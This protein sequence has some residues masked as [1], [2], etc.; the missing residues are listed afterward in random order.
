M[1]IKKGK[2]PIKIWT[3]IMES[4]AM[5]QAVNLSNLPFAFKHIAIMPDTH[6]GIGCPIGSVVA[7]NGIIV[8]NLIGVDIGCVDKDTEFLSPKGWVKISKYKKEEVA[9]FNPQDNYISFTK[10]LAY[11]K[12]K[13]DRFIKI[14]TKYGVD[15]MLSEDHRC[16]I[17]KNDFDYFDMNAKDLMDKHNSLKLGYRHKIKTSFYSEGYDSYGVG[18]SEEMLR[19]LVMFSADGSY[20][21]KKCILQFKK[22][23]KI[24]RAEMLL[25]DADILYNKSVHKNGI[26]R[27]SFYANLKKG[28][29]D[30]WNANKDQ[31][32]IIAEECLYWDGNQKDCF[33][34]SRKE[35]ADFIHYVF[36]SIGYRSVIRLDRKNEYRVFKYNNDLVGI[37]GTPKTKITYSKSK[38]GYKYCFTVPT[39]YLV[40]RRNGNIF[41]TGN[42]GMCAVKTSLTEIDKEI[43][44]KIMGEIRKV[45]PVGF[46][47]H[48]EY[49]SYQSRLLPTMSDDLKICN[50]EFNNA[51]LSLGTLGG[52]NHFIEIQKGSDGFIWIMIHSGSR[53]LG[54]K[55]AEHY[56]K[57]AIELNKK[58]YSE[59]P[60]S[61]ELAYLPVDSAEGQAYIKEMEYCVE[62][63]LANRKLMM[64]RIINCF[65]ENVDVFTCEP[66]INIAHNYASLEN[67]FGE[68]VWV[69]RKGA[70]LAT[71]NTIG[72]IPGSQG[73]KSYIVKG[74][75]NTESFMSCSHG[76]GRLMSRSKAKE[77]LNLANEIKILDDQGI[78]HGIKNIDDLDEASSAY[79]DIDEVME[80][81]KDLVEILVELKPLAVIKG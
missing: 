77:N 43:L 55:V 14:K 6:Q 8:P 48:V 16:L 37:A 22:Q 1:I 47:K 65:S 39:S 19:V 32:H 12:E 61:W 63:A 36:A 10:P 13:C 31:L 33:Y 54:K 81:Q 76:A 3:D 7:T 28:L 58:W 73:T 56:N 26:T 50:Q 75:G 42:C 2:I 52:G 23:R 35:E 74:L 62:F 25:R 64:E 4:G 66:M 40:L 44:K 51:C 41:I 57:I 38:D 53:N 27:I 29:T 79:K 69:H 78:I 70:T 24:D 15:Q 67:H 21:H 34:T 11:I 60:P 30:L 49:E 71:K 80:N 18:Y 17:Y 46:N 68:N 20:S 5:D 9:Q 59:V 45:I 72:I